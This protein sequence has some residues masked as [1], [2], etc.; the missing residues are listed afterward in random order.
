M[1][2]NKT[3]LHDL[4]YETFC[5]SIRNI[6]KCL[7]IKFIKDSEH[8]SYLKQEKDFYI[9]DLDKLYHDGSKGN[10]YHADEV[11]AD[12]FFTK[13]SFTEDLSNYNKSYINL[14]DEYETI[15]EYTNMINEN[16]HKFILME[17]K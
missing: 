15:S 16:T 11:T 10:F 2:N 13:I 17:D 14:L 6:D 1:N 5:I 12:K 8:P 4:I 3:C 7:G 9:N